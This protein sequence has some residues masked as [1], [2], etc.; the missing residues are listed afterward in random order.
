MQTIEIVQHEKDAT[1]ESKGNDEVDFFL[2]G[3]A[4]PCL[5]PDLCL[6]W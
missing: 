6:L 5:A 3:G 1:K 4:F 2:G